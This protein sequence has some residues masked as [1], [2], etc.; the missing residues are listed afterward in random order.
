MGFKSLQAFNYVML[1][2][3]AWKMVTNPGTLIT[4]LFKAKCFPNNDFFG[5]SIG[6]NPSYVWR[7]IWSAIIIVQ[8]GCKWN[9]GTCADIQIWDQCWLREGGSL[10]R[11]PNSPSLLNNMKVK[12]LMRPGAKVW[13]E[14]VIMSLFDSVTVDN[15]LRTP[16][17]NSVRRDA[18]CW[19]LENDDEYSV[20]SAYR[21]YFNSAGIKER[22]GVEGNWRQIWR[23]KLPPKVKNLLWSIARN[24]LPTRVRLA[25][26]MQC[27]QQCGLWT[28]ILATMWI[29]DYHLFPFSLI[30][31]LNSLCI[32]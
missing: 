4:K 14:E 11:P 16:L 17:V 25:K 19:R 7:S 13:N 32:S 31:S 22:H 21:P 18:M 28:K 9:T 23:A 2:K 1:G 27:W 8:E 29:M 15:I 6:H 26:S 30:L 5:S 12:D 3:Q 24:C 10:P 20:R